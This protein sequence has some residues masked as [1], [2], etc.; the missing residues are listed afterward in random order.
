MRLID[1]HHGFKAAVDDLEFPLVSDIVLVEQQGWFEPEVDFIAALAKLTGG[2]MIDV[3]ANVGVYALTWCARGGR[4]AFAVEP[5]PVLLKRL[6]ANKAAN[7]APLEIFPIALAEV[8]GRMGFIP[9]DTA[10]RLAAPGEGINIE[11]QTLDNLF[12][13]RDIAMPIV[14]KIDVE[15]AESRVLA[16]GNRLVRD[17][18]PLV[19]AERS[20]QAAAAL[21][22]LGLDLYRL[23]PGLGCLVPEAND[24]DMIN[25]F[26][27]GPAWR[28]RLIPSGLLADSA[29]GPEM[30][31]D[32]SNGRDLQSALHAWPSGGRSLSALSKAYLAGIHLLKQGP[33]FADLLAFSRVAMDF[34]LRRQ[35]F[36]AASEALNRAA[37]LEERV[38]S[39]EAVEISRCWS[40]AFG[41]TWTRPSLEEIAKDDALTPMLA[42]RL[43][44]MRKLEKLG[45]LPI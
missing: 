27:F 12:A 14:L 5:N 2:T 30:P 17:R 26:A 4:Q 45:R 22:A 31:L 34:G 1:T 21:A 32:L 42:H 37:T 29:G 38:L 16:G 11:V 43:D 39:L 18:D 33:S 13:A 10:G 9:S 36:S 40:I 6:E 19:M 24:H 7:H 25:L 28:E 23:L 20:S 41:G 3:G 15:G 35:A 44:L 8:A